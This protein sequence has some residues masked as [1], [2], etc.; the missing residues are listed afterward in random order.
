MTKKSGEPDAPIPAPIDPPRRRFPKLTLAAAGFTLSVTLALIN[1][2]Y[3]IRG[4]VVVVQPLEQI[5]VYRDGEGAN[6]VMV[7]ATRMAMINTADGAHGD[8]LMQTSLTPI[9]KGPTFNRSGEVQLVFSGAP[10]GSCELGARCISLP[11]LL[12]IEK[13]DHILDIPGGSVRDTYLGYP[14]TLWNCVG[15]SKDCARFADFD[16][17]VEAISGKPL[18]VSVKASFYGDGERTLRCTVRPVDAAYLRKTGWTTA[19]C[20]D[21]TVKGAPLL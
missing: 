6:A 4:S 17:A 20:S 5:I 7:F 1:A 21:A 10:P 13:P 18:T 14:A 15:D 2:F 12:A 19:S 9:A 16:H 11:G 3:A 8:V